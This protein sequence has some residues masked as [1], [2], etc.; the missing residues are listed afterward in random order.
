MYVA[1]CE[2]YDFLRAGVCVTM[3]VGA[4]RVPLMTNTACERDEWAFMSVTPTER[5][6]FPTLITFSMSLT[7]LTTNDVRS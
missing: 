3:L 7:L 5:L 2:Y 1:S 6:L 4:S